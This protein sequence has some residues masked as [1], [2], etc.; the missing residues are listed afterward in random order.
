VEN[1]LEPGKD[2]GQAPARR[3]SLERVAVACM[4]LFLAAV[5]FRVHSWEAYMYAASAEGFLHMSEMF[6]PLHGGAPLPDISRYHPY[7]P[8]FHMLVE[9]L[10]SLPGVNS[11]LTVAVVVNKVSAVAVAVLAFRILRRLL[12]DRV[13][14]VLAVAGMVFTKAFLF[15]AFSGDAHILSLAFFL[16][17][18]DL[19]L[20][21]APAPAADRRRA[22]LAAV[23]FSLGSAMNLAIFFYGLAP[24]AVLLLARRFASA[25]I[26]VGLSAVLL[27][28][29]YV[30]TPVVLFDLEDLDAYS[31]LFGIYS[32]L[33]T[34]EGSL[35]VL[36]G[37]F[38]DAVSAGLVGGIDTLSFAARI[39]VGV[40]LLGGVFA[41]WRAPPNRR[42]PPATRFWVLMWV[43][44]FAAGE[45]AMQTV[46]SVNG[47]IYVML[48]L[49]ALVGFLLRALRERRAAFLV[50]VVALAAVASINIAKVVVTKTFP[51]SEA[52]P[53]LAVV[54]TMPPPE[55]PVAISLA[56][57]SLFQEIHHLGHDRGFRTMKVF[58]PAVAESV[59]AQKA[60]LGQQES[61]C[62]L[63]STP[64]RE[65]GLRTLVRARVQLSPDLYHFSVNH[66]QSKGLITKRV[67]F[68]CR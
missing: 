62:V 6:E 27:F 29:V 66:P 19:T 36:M 14:A 47:T 40:L 55:T 24:L 8:L 41:F 21:P 7:H 11:A 67:H 13:S 54:R 33:P 51:G 22:V 23:L 68:A 61:A 9:A 46:K 35:L 60:W 56:H 38:L 48:P 2:D 1:E 64:V 30:V 10:L 26:A 42:T 57:M 37:E 4:A 39:L 65:P 52:A 44:G 49:F 12:D 45:L 17:T 3:L 28:G 5:W 32:Y 18:L 50:V 34:P 58:V 43:I 20:Q 31:R 25:G 63:S 16:G 15:G 53:R 59:A